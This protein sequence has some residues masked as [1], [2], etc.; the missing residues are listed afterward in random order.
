[1]LG[2]SPSSNIIFSV[3][4][5]LVTPKDAAQPIAPVYRGKC[6]GSRNQRDTPNFAQVLLIPTATLSKFAI[7][8]LTSVSRDLVGDT[9][10][11]AKKRRISLSPNGDKLPDSR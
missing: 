8:T 6:L 3:V 9:T 1:M 11:P 10:T 2:R 7:K 5:R 4:E